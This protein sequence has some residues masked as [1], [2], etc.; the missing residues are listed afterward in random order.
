MIFNKS[1]TNKKF[2]YTPYYSKY[3]YEKLKYN[4][5]TLLFGTSRS[6]KVST[7]E[8]NIPL[9]NFHNIY[10]EPDSVYNFL[11]Q[12]D[13]NQIKNIKHIYYLI[14]IDTMRD[15]GL[16]INYKKNSFL[17]KII[18]SLPLQSSTIKSILRDIKYNLFP[19]TIFYNIDNDGSLLV[20][21]KSQSSILNRKIIV[22]SSIEKIKLTKSIQTL[23]EINQFCVNNNIS[24]TYYTPTFSDKYIL[25]KDTV[26]FLWTVLLDGGLK[27][28]YAT[29]YIDNFSNNCNNNMYYNF[30]DETHLNYISMNKVFKSIVLSK[31]QSKYI[32]NTFELKNLLKNYEK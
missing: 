1:M 16:K 31:D 14:S 13:R 26:E 21:D 8:L 23:L 28:F 3:Q 11:S 27:G 29:Y 30:T 10:G 12:L 4:K 7:R 17:D 25:H 5:Y 9:L 20:K 32:N 22:S 18:Y 15:S 19:S 24:I 6:Q 2:E